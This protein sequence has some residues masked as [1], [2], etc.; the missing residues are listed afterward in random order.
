MYLLLKASPEVIS[1][2]NIIFTFKNNFEVVLFNK[3]YDDIQKFLKML[4]NVKYVLVAVTDEEWKLIKNQYI[5]DKKNGIKYEYI[6]EKQTKKK[7]VKNTELQNSL[8]NIFGSDY[9]TM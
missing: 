9:I 4:Y 2:K 3:N 5:S 7:S 8:E 1:D 6:E